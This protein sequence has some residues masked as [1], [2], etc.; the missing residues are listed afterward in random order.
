M[1]D[2]SYDAGWVADAW[3][4][5]KGQN[6]CVHCSHR[7]AHDVGLISIDSGSQSTACRKDSAPHYDINE[8]EKT[9][10]WHIQGQEIKSYGRK[11]V[12]VEFLGQGDFKKLEASLLVDV[13]DVGKNVASMGRLLRVGSDA[14]FTRERRRCWM[15]R[16]GLGATIFQDD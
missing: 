12:D 6:L 14:N 15:E 8:A 16:D 11:A 10:L 7:A 5:D 4:D 3:H 9:R 1:E 13:S 2:W